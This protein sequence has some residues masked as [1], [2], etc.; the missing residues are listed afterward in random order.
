MEPCKKAVL[1]RF[2]SEEHSLESIEYAV[3]TALI[4]GAIVLALIGLAGAM[5]DKFIETQQVLEGVN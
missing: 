5:A 3:M 1:K 2:L 4:V